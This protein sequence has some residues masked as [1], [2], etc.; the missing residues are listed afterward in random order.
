MSTPI[1]RTGLS[2]ISSPSAGDA[3]FFGSASKVAMF[4][5]FLGDVIAD[6]WNYTEGT[7]ASPTDGAILAGG[8]GGVLRL[9]TGDAGTGLAA[10]LACLSTALQWQAS[11]GG[12]SASARVKF[13]ALTVAYFFFGFTD[14]PTL[15]A[16]VISA[17]SA[18]TI[19]TTASDAVGFMFDTR[20]AT[21]DLWLVGVKGDTDAVAQ[22]SLLAPE[23]GEYVEF[24]VDVDQ[25][26]SASFFVDGVQVGSTMVNA[27]TPATDLAPV[28]CFGNL[29]GTASKT[30]DIDYVNVSMNRGANGG[31]V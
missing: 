19:T 29:S 13:S 15:E 3:V 24:R 1:G 25:L 7:D 9:T 31:A 6:Q 12:L 16:P 2:R 30:L 28:V 14:I 18:D 17:G 4:D 20:M 8:I 22:D 5:D 27:V 21:D 26:G 23:A 10:D 11:N